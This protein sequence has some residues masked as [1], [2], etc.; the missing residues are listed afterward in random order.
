MV[1]LQIINVITDED[2]D[3]YHVT[4]KNGLR[5]EFEVETMEIE[6]GTTEFY[7]IITNTLKKPVI[8]QKNSSLVRL[9]P[10]N[11]NN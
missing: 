7:A 3:R 9:R 6:I 10:E 1:K 4:E 8:L 5:P 2:K 11:F